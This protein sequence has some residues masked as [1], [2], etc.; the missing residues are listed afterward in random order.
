MVKKH[1][2]RLHFYLSHYQAMKIRKNELKYV[3]KIRHEVMLFTLKKQ[4][5]K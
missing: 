5:S 4:S 3:M 1:G 2:K